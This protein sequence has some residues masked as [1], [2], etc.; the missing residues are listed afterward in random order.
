MQLRISGWG[1]LLVATGLTSTAGAAPEHFRQSMTTPGTLT[2]LPANLRAR[3]QTSQPLEQVIVR[4]AADAAARLGAVDVASRRTQLNAIEAE[5]GQFMSRCLKLPGNIRVLARVQ[6]VLN[7]VFLEVDARL[8]PLIESDPAVVRVAPVANYEKTLA[9][10]VPYI[11]ATAVQNTGFNGA[12]IKVAVLDSG[13]D[14][15]HANLGGSGE[16]ADHAGNDPTL[17]ET[18]TFP[19]AKVVGGFDFVGQVWP[20]GDLAPDPDPLDLDGHGTH[21]AD[22]IGGVN[23]VAPGADIYGIQVCSSVSSSCSGIALI[24]GM[25][26]AVDP[27]GDGD[28]SDAVD[29]INMSLGADYGKP[30][31]DDLSLAVDNASA[32]GVLTVS[33][34]GNGGDN[35]YVSGTPAGA[36]T[37][38]SVAQTNVPSAEQAQLEI[39]EPA[40]SSGLYPAV[41]QAWSAPQVDPVSGPIQYADGTGGNLT[42]CDPFADGALA[43]QIVMVDRGGC[44]FTTKIFNIGNAGGVLGIIG[45]VAP[46]APFSGGFADPGGPITIPGYMISQADADIIRG[47]GAVG[48]F[49]PANNLSLA[50]AMV[51][52]SA[53][54][55]TNTNIIKPEIGAPGASLSAEAGTGTGE[56]PF[57]GTSGASPMAAGAAALLLEARGPE[58]Y[59]AAGKKKIMITRI[60]KSL[61]VNT[62][63]A[64]VARDFTGANAEITRIGGGEVRVDRAVTTPAIAWSIEDENPALSLGFHDISKRR[65]VIRRTVVVKNFSNKAVVYNPVPVFLFEDDETSGV[66][67]VSAPRRVRVP[68]NRSR[69]FRVR[70]TIDGRALSGNPMSSGAEGTDPAALRAAEFDGY[71]ALV[72]ANGA[73]TIHLPWHVIPRKAAKV[74][75]SVTKVQPKYDA[76]V[77]LRNRGIGVAQTEAF[78]LVATSPDLPEGPQGAQAPTPDL[79]AVGVR[80]DP[81]PAGVCSDAESFVWSFAVTTHERQA[82]LLNVQPVIDL[83]LDNDGT[84]EFSVVGFDNDG[85]VLS[86]VFD[87]NTGDGNFF[88]FA[89]H[90]MNTANTVLRTCAEQFGL[91]PADLGKRTVTARAS[92]NDVTF[93]GPGDSTEDFVLAPGGE[94][95]QLSLDAE[96]PSR[97][98]ARLNITDTGSSTGSPTELG[99]LVVTNT[100]FGAG[101]HGGATRATEA[102]L[103]TYPGVTAY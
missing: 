51:G 86:A 40:A 99:V 102:L 54:G 8:I 5:Q 15:L 80:M 30:F 57:G 71:L 7:A 101:A 88:F 52:S 25:D 90:G 35:P 84:F 14:Y 20:N 100:S 95:Y 87:N 85:Q 24:Q 45:L 50:G 13:V 10:T 66:I 53:R 75:Q 77:R 61:I 12:G 79:R 19:T 9:E 78:T 17:I 69:K 6:T 26:F 93:G 67:S 58:I 92:V 41:F 42:G 44:T 55:P 81:V 97:T 94:R 29:V 39:S 63:F 21:V 16:P 49:D 65:K 34:A 2:E 38:L 32:L 91:T 83:D 98:T 18:G 56:T 82:H 47:G 103:V 48:K 46:G 73:Q 3:A 74:R 70:W 43:G 64:F 96:I 22:I 4:L 62:G 1:A 11:G 33:S 23:G 31:D 27:N 60:L 89:E 68:A 72:G 76:L 37:A 59:E 28:T 36:P